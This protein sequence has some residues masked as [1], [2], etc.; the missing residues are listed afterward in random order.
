MKWVTVKLGELVVAKF[1][2]E[3]HVLIAE[4]RINNMA[5]ISHMPLVVPP[6]QVLTISVEEKP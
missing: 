6:G 1:G 4:L 2:V 3:E 5:L